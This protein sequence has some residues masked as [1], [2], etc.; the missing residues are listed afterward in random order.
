MPDQS[1]RQ[2]H[3]DKLASAREALSQIKN[4][5]TTF[6]SSGTGEPILLTNTLAE[7]AD[8]FRDI[9]VIHL[10]AMHEDSNLARPELRN[11]FRFNRYYVGQ[12]ISAVLGDGTSDYTPMDIAELPRA[13]ADG[14]VLIDAALIQVSPPDAS[15]LCS[16][17][18]S[19]DAT[20]V[21]V[22]HA[23]LVIAQVNANMPV[24]MGDSLIP[25]ETI[26]FLVE[27]SMLLTESPP[28]E[29]DPVSLTIGRHVATLIED[30][31]VLH[32]ERGPIGASTMRYLDTKQD[33]G[34]HTDVLTDD[35]MRLIRSRAVT[36]R[37]KQRNKGKSVATMVIGSRRL[38]E[39]VHL[40]PEI[41]I[42]P[43]EEVMDQAL[44]SQN[45]N[46]VSVHSVQEIELTGMARI[47][48]DYL[49]QAGSLP[50]SMDFVHGARR[51][52]GGFTVLALPST[53]PDG[54]ASR[55]VPLVTGRGVFFPRAK[56][57]FVVTEYGVVNLH[58]LSVRERAIALIHIAHPKFRQALLE[59]AK[60]LNY[61]GPEQVVPPLGGCVYPHQYEFT[62]AFK[63]GTE[64][65]FRPVRPSD[66]RRLQQLF[67]SLSPEARRMRYHGTI[68]ALS[69]ETAQRMAAVDYSQDIAM[70]GLV[71]PRTNQQ[72][73]A[74]GRCMYNPANNMGEF[75]L[76]V[77]E[78]Y[79]GRGIGK[80]LANYLG[81]IAYARGLS[82]VYAEVVQRNDATISLMNKAW[83]TAVRNFESG[84]CTFVLR[85]PEEDVERPKDSIVVYSGRFGDFSYGEEHPFD[86]GRARAALR[87][88]QEQGYL[89]EPWMRIEEPVEITRKRLVESHNPA[90]IDA[91]EEASSGVWKEEFL[92]H[93]LGGDDC[94]VFPG[95]FEYVLLYTSATITGANL[96]MNEN[97]NVVFNP[98]GGF[99]HAS[100]AH[101]EG[102]CYVND[103]LA[104]IDMFIAGGFRVAYVDIDAHHGNGVQDTYYRDDRV[105]TISL[106]QTG[107]TL[108]P[109]SG[110]ETEIGDDAGKGFNINIPL[111]EETDDEAFEGVFDR[112]VT[113]AV[114]AFA[115]RIVVAVIGGDTH[116]SDPL[117][118]LSLTNNGMVAAMKRIRDFATHLLLLGG[119][120]YDVQA[121]TRA[122]SRMWAAAN[123]IDALP[124]YLLVMGGSFFGGDGIAG[125]D[126]VDRQYVLSGDKKEAIIAELDRIAEYHEQTTI[127]I[128]TK[129]QR[130]GRPTVPPAPE[131][132]SQ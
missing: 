88:I 131:G 55:I 107:K 38:Y 91:L 16:L 49:T 122:W 5:Q 20:R 48:E 61:V 97:A 6:L 30:G 26:D 132:E 13:I 21:A 108:Y 47:D 7:M 24:T 39:Q 68:K 114:T 85:F 19:V 98:L 99:H 126:V 40:N 41:E 50:S 129:R 110:F 53:T 121:T 71:G 125:A 52:K 31:M 100:R 116:R 62:R 73:V 32:V 9:E 96:I 111:P 64:I 90:Y 4:G 36:N 128:I 127:P 29:I 10:G 3:S 12:G 56:V 69:N 72:I 118:N 54:S 112:V 119:G 2:I 67:Y 105:L 95:L 8:E 23:E 80:F 70:V 81:K 117:A 106:H 74:E 101:A 42:L 113:K 103:V 87:L 35:I 65:F 63:D 28:P 45:D 93:N 17:G 33:L 14:T 22:E 78:D 76:V 79:Q 84:Y 15:G 124:D 75:D 120:G 11:S 82:G 102:F 66:A 130:G 115:P 60:R 77:R 89:D 123:R 18:V 57:D 43:I 86:P 46:M 104:A 27:G 92:Q 83:P 58:G 109:Y 1:W 37:L 44:I 59:E 51:S 94:P 34:I 25:V